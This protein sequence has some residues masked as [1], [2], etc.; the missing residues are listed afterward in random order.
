MPGYAVR[1]SRHGYKAL[2]HNLNPIAV[3]SHLYVA[4]LLTR[5]VDCV[6]VKRITTFI[7]SAA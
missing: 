5:T 7:S 2:L 1:L 3:W 4:Q 6:H